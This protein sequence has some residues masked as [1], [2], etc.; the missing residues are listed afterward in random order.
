MMIAAIDPGTKQS[1]F[2]LIATAHKPPHILGVLNQGIFANEDLILDVRTIISAS[3]ELLIIEEIA[4]MGSKCGQ[5]VFKTA[6]W[7]GRFVEAWLSRTS[8]LPI[9]LTSHETKMRICGQTRGVKDAGVRQVMI[10]RYGGKGKAVGLKD[11]PG[12]FYG[13]K[14]HNWRALALVEAFLIGDGK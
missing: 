9:R 10:D 12:I 11:S 2:V 4:Y 8:C 14:S 5:E 3:A 13:I 1:G 6:E 7:A